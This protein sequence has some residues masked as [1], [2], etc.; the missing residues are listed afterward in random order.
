[1]CISLQLTFRKSRR[2][3]FTLNI[4][5][6]GMASMTLSPP[7]V[8]HAPRKA[9]RDV[10]RQQ[11][12]DATIRVLGQKGFA[13]L[14]VAD[15]A[16]T[17]GLSAGIVIFHFNSKDGLLAEVL[18]F[19]AE[20]FRHGW[21]S[22]LGGAEPTPEKQLEAMLMSDFS[23]VNCA[24]DRLAAWLAFWAEAQGRPTYDEICS[25]MDA[26]RMDTIRLLCR[27]IIEVN[28]YALDPDVTALNIEALSDGLWFR[29]GTRGPAYANRVTTESA[30]TAMRHALAV[31]FP[32]HFAAP[33]H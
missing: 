27:K 6:L 10:R 1:V 11:L 15:V 2:R 33:Q 24:P 21:Q 4:R 7:D 29:L 13:A 5:R 14:T 20:E 23:P 19:L 3:D 8:P 26:E 22:A 30:R 12:I 32:R 17:A 28:G 18:R 25:A 9:A 16:K 31:A